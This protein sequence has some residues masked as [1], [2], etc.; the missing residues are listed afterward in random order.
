MDIRLTLI[1]RSIV[2]ARAV[3]IYARLSDPNGNPEVL[4]SIRAF[5]V[6]DPKLPGAAPNFARHKLTADTAAPIVAAYR[7]HLDQAGSTVQQTRAQIARAR[8]TRHS[9]R[10]LIGWAA[11][12]FYQTS[13]QPIGP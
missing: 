3:L 7:N 8:R 2:R 13:Q 11:L 1:I 9:A 5:P 6:M 4:Y 10:R 12:A